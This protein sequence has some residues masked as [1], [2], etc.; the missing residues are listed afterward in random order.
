MTEAQAIA[1]MLAGHSIQKAWPTSLAHNRG[2]KRFCQTC[3]IEQLHASLWNVDFAL[4]V[5]CVEK[6]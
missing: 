6:L 5:S 4:E 2:V 1:C 3:Y